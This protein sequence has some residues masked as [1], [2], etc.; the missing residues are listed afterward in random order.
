MKLLNPI[1]SVKK[2]YFQ[3]PIHFTFLSIGIV[4]KIILL[5]EVPK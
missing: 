5:G 1:K 3:V 2:I 4:K